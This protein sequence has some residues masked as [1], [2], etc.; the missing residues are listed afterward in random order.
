MQ[1]AMLNS[2]SVTRA[3][4]LLLPICWRFWRVFLGF[5]DL[6]LWIVASRCHGFSTIAWKSYVLIVL[7]KRQATTQQI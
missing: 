6:F 3:A 1:L 7:D 5:T 4:P 2:T